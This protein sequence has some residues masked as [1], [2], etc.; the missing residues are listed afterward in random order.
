MKKSI[1]LENF[2]DV[3]A[4]KMTLR[5]VKLEITH[6]MYHKLPQKMI[7]ELE[8]NK[9]HGGYYTTFYIPVKDFIQRK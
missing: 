9:E 1:S 5:Q 4:G 6:Q 3:C 7:I 8:K 2:T